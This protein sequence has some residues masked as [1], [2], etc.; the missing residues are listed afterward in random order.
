MVFK[1][2]TTGLNELRKSCLSE[3]L[4][5]GGDFQKQLLKGIQKVVLL[6][7]LFLKLTGLFQNPILKQ[8]D[9]FFY[10]GFLS[11]TFTN[12]SNAGV[13]GGHFVNSSLPLPSASKAL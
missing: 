12:H 7:R 2:L 5:F 13:E 11:R 3:C 9:F 6:K 1:H 4:R 8:K 10:L